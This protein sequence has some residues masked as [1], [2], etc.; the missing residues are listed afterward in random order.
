MGETW[1]IFL[2]G[3]EGK[4]L[5]AYTNGTPKQ[6]CSFDGRRTMLEHTLRRARGV[7]SPWRMVTVIGRGHL[8]WLRPESLTGFVLEQPE[9]K[10]TAPG[11]LLPLSTVLAHDSR[12]VVLVFPCDHFIQPVPAYQDLLRRAADLSVRLPDRILLLGA[13]ADGPETEYG[14]IEAGRSLGGGAREV[15]RFHEKPDAAAARRLYDSGGL[16]NT[17]I[18]AGRAETFWRLTKLFLPGLTARFEPLRRRLGAP[19][20]RVYEG[21]P[22]ANFSKAVL[23]RGVGNVAVLPMDGVEWSD[24]GRI[25]RI[26]ATLGNNR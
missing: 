23:E 6:Y 13:R 5:A 1:A 24:W 10:E 19:L 17:F 12:A 21:L 4:R 3:G 26:D 14:W 20:G 7:V 9:N 2:C 25:E 22:S 18:M 8:R 15:L 11:L 16:W